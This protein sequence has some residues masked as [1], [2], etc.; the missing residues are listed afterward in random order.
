MAG[1]SRQS[2]PS[3]QRGTAFQ[4]S[5]SMSGSVVTLP[6]FVPGDAFT[7]LTP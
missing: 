7:V 3:H 6:V 2:L 1:D 4:S 5:S